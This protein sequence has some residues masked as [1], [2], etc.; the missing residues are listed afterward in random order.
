MLLLAHACKPNVFRREP[1]PV[2]PLN[3]K[4]NWP[5]S[6]LLK[7]IHDSYNAVLL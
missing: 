4:N 7:N 6:Y 2:S 5:Y 1:A 3:S